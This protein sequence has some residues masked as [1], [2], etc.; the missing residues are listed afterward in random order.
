MPAEL[1]YGQKP[2]MPTERT[3]SSWAA[4][5]WNEVLPIWGQNLLL[6]LDRFLILERLYLLRGKLGCSR[7]NSIPLSS[8]FRYFGISCILVEFVEFRFFEFRAFRGLRV[9]LEFCGFW[10]F[11]YFWDFM[12]I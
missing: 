8:V 7:Q 9:F 10:N 4:M 6:S 12:I 1:M 3:I 5:D 2:I 11:V